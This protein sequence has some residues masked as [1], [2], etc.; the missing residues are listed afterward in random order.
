MRKI[1]Q[2]IIQ[3]IE[4]RFMSKQELKLLRII[5]VSL[6]FLFIFLLDPFMIYV[7]EIA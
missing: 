1:Q 5:R 7:S 6:L 4:N 3:Q 2:L